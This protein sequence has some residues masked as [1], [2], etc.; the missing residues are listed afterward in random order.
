MS[1]GHLGLIFS[2]ALRLLWLPMG[3][4]RFL[5]LGWGFLRAFLFDGLGREGIWVLD[6]EAVSIRSRRHPVFVLS[7]E[8]RIR[9]AIRV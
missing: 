7:V 8:A 2:L 9:A 6:V 1:R 4:L 5:L 3:C